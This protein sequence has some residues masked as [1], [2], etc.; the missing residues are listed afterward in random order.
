MTRNEDIR[1]GEI[2]S[3]DDI[4]FCLSDKEKSD[5]AHRLG[6]ETEKLAEAL[7]DKVQLLGNLL[8]SRKAQ[9]ED[10]PTKGQR[11]AALRQL[12]ASKDFVSSLQS[13]NHAAESALIDALE[14]QKGRPWAQH[15]NIQDAF[16]LLEML[17]QAEPS[18]D[19]NAI[20]AHIRKA[21][22]DH[23]DFLQSK[24]EEKPSSLQGRSGPK[25]PISTMYF[26]DD[27]LQLYHELTGKRPTHSSRF[28][29]DGSE[30][31]NSEAGLFIEHVVDLI[32]LRLK[33]DGKQQ[34]LSTTIF[35]QVRDGCKRF[36]NKYP[37]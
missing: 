33:Q 31:L 9:Y 8:L 29:D 37:K 30:R 15:T 36:R 23:L 7:A 24:L 10:G 13:L 4:V 35:S 34:I 1:A 14:E 16:S 3:K 20:I 32:N 5:L 26:V 22:K 12:L 28:N 6:L 25:P 19:N 2:I 18:D 11:N 21:V 17:K 27:L